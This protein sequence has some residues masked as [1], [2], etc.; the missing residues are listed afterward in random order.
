MI[1]SAS[2]YLW[3]F[4]SSAIVEVGLVEV[5]SHVVA[6][7]RG[8][9]IDRW[10]SVDGKPL[11]VNSFVNK[12]ELV[13]VLDDSPLRLIL[14][15]LNRRITTIRE[16]VSLELEKFESEPTGPLP[17]AWQ[18]I[19]SFSDAI[20]QQI[21]RLNQELELRKIDFEVTM[22]KKTAVESSD[23][24]RLQQLQMK[25]SIAAAKLTPWQSF[26]SEDAEIRI[27]DLFEIN[28]R[29]FES[30]DRILFLK[31]R[32]TCQ[33]IDTQLAK[34]QIAAESLDI[35]S[36]CQGQVDR[37]YVQPN[38]TV[39]D[40]APILA[41]TAVQGDFIVVYARENSGLLPTPGA[42]V[43]IAIRGNSSS[44]TDSIIE[45]V[46][47]KIVAI[48]AR[49]RL[50]SNIEE[51]GRAVRIPV[52]ADLSVVPGSLVDVTF[53]P[54]RKGSPSPIVTAKNH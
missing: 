15:E 53:F 52:P 14:Q 43:A 3:Q 46:G 29:Q 2:L 48:P 51:W 25:R 17:L 11:P 30:A 37:T 10:A 28:E 47:A 31:L 19:A 18:S 54:G 44:K 35:T 9:K 1:C 50:N 12:N 16:T 38:E 27:S 39:A 33:S 42:P 6:S 20:D 22:L 5:V 23:M 8:G 26:D 41:L 32:E 24:R 34:T 36:P 13:A 49:Q 7:P 4:K 21:V 40:G 45:S